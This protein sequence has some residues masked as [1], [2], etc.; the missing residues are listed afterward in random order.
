[1]PTEAFQG[2]FRIISGAAKEYWG[3]AFSNGSMEACGRVEQ[4]SGHASLACI[5]HRLR[6]GRSTVSA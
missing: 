1:M 6:A 3:R 2:T 5:R 4:L